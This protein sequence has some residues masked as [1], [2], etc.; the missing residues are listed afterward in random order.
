MSHKIYTESIEDTRSYPSRVEHAEGTSSKKLDLIFALF[1][2][3]KNRWPITFFTALV[4]ALAAFYVYTATPIYA[5]RATLLLESQRA[6]II[7]IEDLVSSEQ[8]SIDYFGTQFVMLRSRALAERVT[9]KLERDI[10]KSPNSLGAELTTPDLKQTV[11]T[12]SQLVRSGV[13][14]LLRMLRISDTSINIDDVQSLPTTETSLSQGAGEDGAANTSDGLEGLEFNRLVGQFRKSL[15][16]TPIKSTKLVIITF[17]SPDAKFA[18]LAANT[19]ANQYIR[20]GL[21]SRLEK[22][23]Q[24]SQWMTGRITQLKGKLERSEQALLEFKDVNGLIDLNGGVGRLNEQELLMA[25]TELATARSELSDARD[26]YREIQKL[27]ASAPQLLETY[28]AVQND[29]LVRSVK[30]EYG[31]RQRDLDGL[32]NRYGPKHPR[33]IDAQSRLESL[34]LTLDGHIDRIVATIENDYQLREQRVASVQASLARG[35]EDIQVI[36]QKKIILEGLEREVATN[37][38]QYNRLFNR[39]SETDTADGLDAANAVLAEAALVPGGPIKPNKKLILAL[40]VLGSLA[41]STAL[42]FLYEFFDDTVK[43]TDDV[44]RRLGKKLVGI[45][46]LIEPG[47]LGRRNT[48]PLTPLNVQDERGTFAEAVNTCRTALS[49]NEGS[50]FQVILVT[51]SVPDEGKSTA[52]LNL[53]YSFGQLERTLLIDCDLRRPSLAKALGLPMNHVGLSSLLMQKSSAEE[54]IRRDVMNSIDCLTSGP[55]PDQ[56]LEMLSSVRFAKILEQLR[57]HYDKIIIDSAPTHAVSDALVLSKLSDTVLYIV[58]SHDTSIAL[59]ESGLSRLSEVGATVAGIWMSK[60]D[61]N[62]LTSYGG[63][64]FHG[65]YDYYGYSEKGGK[66]SKVKLTPEEMRVMRSPDKDPKLDLNFYNRVPKLDI[67]DGFEKD[68]GSQSI[69]EEFDM[70]VETDFKNEKR[71]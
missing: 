33:V 51:S 21:D 16:V 63:F 1:V 56:P 17:E 10:K 64:K 66:N 20:S 71:G 37:R 55:I 15:R 25:T 62:K 54:C 6:N 19:I 36:G 39:I 60:V 31:Q 23:N 38:D 35:K 53:A 8:E 69:N 26:L 45:L 41:L 49:L 43:S 68:T 24:A 52:A 28:P 27:N 2:L 34:R 30:I 59:I 5:A 46:P 57:Q 13:S 4:T 42:A 3:R 47:F 12:V 48:L 29:P 61:I 32:Q 22:K 40:A 11:A 14:K 44:E 65:F 18:A 50:D 67:L 70:T 58:K 7:S 9:R